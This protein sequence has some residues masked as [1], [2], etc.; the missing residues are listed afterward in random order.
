MTQKTPG[1]FLHKESIYQCN[2]GDTKPAFL[3]QYQQKSVL[4]FSNAGFL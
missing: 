1:L 4:N 3:P 2:F